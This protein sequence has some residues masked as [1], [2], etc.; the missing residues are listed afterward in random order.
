[1]L[2]L[3]L[4]KMQNWEEPQYALTRERTK[5]GW[6]QKGLQ[7]N[8]E[9]DQATANNSHRVGTPQKHHAQQETIF[10]KAQIQGP[11]GYIH[12]EQTAFKIGEGGS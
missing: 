4:F 10:Y 11:L 3:T 12:T 2:T 8:H 7:G 1:M 6:S 5:G 9:D